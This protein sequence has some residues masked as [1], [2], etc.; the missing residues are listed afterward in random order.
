MLC[1]EF[2]AVD[3]I[4][5]AAKAAND[6][7]MLA[8]ASQDLIA[9]EAHYHS[10]CYKSYTKTKSGKPK[11]AD[12]VSYKE[13]EVIAFKEVI[14]ICHELLKEKQIKMF[15]ELL[16]TMEKIFEDNGLVI[17]SATRN[18]LRRN[19]EK[20]AD[21]IK[22]I[23]VNSCLYV[24]PDSLTAEELLRQHII[25]LKK[26]DAITRDLDEPISL[27][28]II[29]CGKTIRTEIKELKDTLPWP[30]QPKDL[31]PESIQI[32]SSLNVFFNTVLD[33]RPRR[34]K[35][36]LAQDMIYNVSAGRIKTAKSVLLPSIVKTLSK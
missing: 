21:D 6:F 25:T 10:S 7:Q 14:T 2:R 12:K 11:S 1:M 36:S 15:Q 35:L 4:K 27:Q 18:Y 32:P 16:K 3:S 24:Y 33:G 17:R 28:N 13:V 20:H 9:S 31:S 8:L 34:L 22:Y 23:N 5:K 19:L 29:K 26:L 30:P